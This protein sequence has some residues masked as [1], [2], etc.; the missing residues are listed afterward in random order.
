MAV[1]KRL[2]VAKNGPAGLMLALALKALKS[3]PVQARL[4]E[5]PDA[6]V[7]WAQRRRAQRFGNVIDVEEAAGPDPAPEGR[8]ASPTSTAASASNPPRPAPSA[9]SAARRAGR[10]TRAVS[11]RWTAR[12]DHCDGSTRHLPTDRLRQRSLERRVIQLAAGFETAFSTTSGG[13]PNE[14]TTA[15]DDLR[16]ALGATAGLPLMKRT[17][18]HFRIADE[19]DKLENALIE[20]VLPR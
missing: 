2:A 4:K 13:V 1:N 16:R 6:A 19:L 14:V 3:E 12:R 5:A 18:S 8:A 17:R 9:I 10:A 11:E 20:A 15:L 7:R